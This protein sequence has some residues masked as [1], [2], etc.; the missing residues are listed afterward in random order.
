MCNQF[1][2]LKTTLWSVLVAHFKCLV[3]C[4]RVMQRLD[5]D[6]SHVS[7]ADALCD[8]IALHS[9]KQHLC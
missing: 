8:P 5:T 9:I 1:I 6:I 4:G 2:H 3:A 7:T